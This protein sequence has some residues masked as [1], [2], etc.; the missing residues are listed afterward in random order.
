[1]GRLRAVRKIARSGELIVISAADPLNL[2]GILTPDSRVT[3][4]AQN[5]VLFRDGVAIAAWEGGSVRRLSASELDDETLHGLL[6]RRASAKPLKPHFRT[7]TQR[8]RELLE[9]K[10]LALLDG[11]G[12]SDTLH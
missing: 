6:S 12:S 2:V 1:V 11:T 3:S 4:I 10:R 5:R 7:P 9:R 8:E